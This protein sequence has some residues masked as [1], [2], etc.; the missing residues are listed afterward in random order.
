MLDFMYTP[1]TVFLNKECFRLFNLYKRNHIAD[2]LLRFLSFLQYHDSG[3]YLCTVM[4]LF[5]LNE[6]TRDLF[7]HS[8]DGCLHCFQNFAVMSNSPLQ[9]CLYEGISKSSGKRKDHFGAKK[10]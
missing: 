9:S 3:I 5:S 10:F 1:D 2:N 7:I 4:H 8:V 6:H